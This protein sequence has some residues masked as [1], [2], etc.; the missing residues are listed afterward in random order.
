ME[1]ESG[2]EGLEGFAGV[3]IHG[4]V[5]S[6]WSGT[7]TRLKT[8][9]TGCGK[10]LRKIRVTSIAERNVAGYPP[11]YRAIMKPTEFSR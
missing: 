3:C 1:G 6:V 2:S 4:N 5:R 10:A 8:K 9:V 11:T 7:Q